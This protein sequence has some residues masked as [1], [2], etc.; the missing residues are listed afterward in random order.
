M[1]NVKI[2]SYTVD[3]SAKTK[4]ENRNNK[5]SLLYFLNELS[6]VYSEAAK[7]NQEHGFNGFYQDFEEK[8]RELHQMLTELGAY[9]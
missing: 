4:Y 3:I 1:K 2:G 5:E 8:S 7:Y 9:D 6:I